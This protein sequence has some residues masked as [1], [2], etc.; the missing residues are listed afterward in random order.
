[1]SY[2]IKCT[3]FTNENGNQ[4]IISKSIINDLKIINTQRYSISFQ[5]INSTNDDIKI[6]NNDICGNYSTEYYFSVPSDLIIEYNKIKLSI[7]NC[8]EKY[9]IKYNSNENE[10]I[11]YI[12]NNDKQDLIDLLK[13]HQINYKV[14][15]P[16]DDNTKNIEL[17]QIQYNEENGYIYDQ[18]SFIQGALYY[19][20]KI[21]EERKKIDNFQKIINSTEYYKLDLAQRENVTEDL[22]CADELKDL[23]ESCYLVCR[24]MINLFEYFGREEI[25][26]DNWNDRNCKIYC[27][28]S[29]I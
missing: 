19:N 3:F 14:N 18:N 22:E 5:D 15:N 2:D 9:A 17:Y 27:Y 7:Q 8:L 6:N 11:K 13:K 12:I 23:F 28:I 24:K 16:I 4:K 20:N 29:A 26:D 21:E 1:M 25:I 10:S